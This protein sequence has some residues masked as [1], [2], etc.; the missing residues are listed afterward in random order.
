MNPGRSR[1]RRFRDSVREK[2]RLLDLRQVRFR[3]NPLQDPYQSNLISPVDLSLEIWPPVHCGPGAH[4][5]LAQVLVGKRALTLNREGGMSFP[6]VDLPQWGTGAGDVCR[7]GWK[8]MT[9]HRPAR[10][11][12]SRCG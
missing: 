8:K 2:S 11:A 1:P 4:F 7:A 3:E 10:V 9:R 5:A 12:A 6:V